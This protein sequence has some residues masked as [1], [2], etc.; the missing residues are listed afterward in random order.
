MFICQEP[1]QHFP[2]I[3]YEKSVMVTVDHEHIFKICFFGA[4]LACIILL[5]AS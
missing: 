5:A 3:F 2:Q 1:Q 4:L